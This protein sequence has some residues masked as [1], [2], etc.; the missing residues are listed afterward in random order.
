MGG[1]RLGRR[2]HSCGALGQYRQQFEVK[3]SSSLR[4]YC[5]NDEVLHFSC[6]PDMM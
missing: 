5:R 6:E 4:R 2:S 3:K 1:V